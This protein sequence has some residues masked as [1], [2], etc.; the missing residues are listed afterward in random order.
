MT[1]PTPAVFFGGDGSEMS[2]NSCTIFKK[3]LQLSSVKGDNTAH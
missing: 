3:E 1:A 2:Q